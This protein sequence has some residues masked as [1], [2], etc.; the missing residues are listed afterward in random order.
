MEFLQ[1]SKLEALIAAAQRAASQLTMAQSET[2]SFSK[3]KKDLS[4]L[5]PL[6]R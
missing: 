4:L 6:Q 5:N 3:L 1:L 2:K